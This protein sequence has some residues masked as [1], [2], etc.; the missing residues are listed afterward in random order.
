MAVGEESFRR[1]RSKRDRCGEEISGFEQIDISG[2]GDNLLTLS[3]GDVEGLSDTD[4][5]TVNGDSLG[6]GDS[7]DAGSGWTDTGTVTPSW[8]R[9][10]TTPTRSTRHWRRRESS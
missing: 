6:G 5:L 9:S 3:A 1:C 8:W 10:G 7:I 4:T 2:T